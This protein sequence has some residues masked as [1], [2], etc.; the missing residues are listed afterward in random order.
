MGRY[1]VVD[2]SGNVTNVIV[3]DGEAQ[4]TPP[5]GTELIEVT[6]AAGPGWTYRDGEFIAPEEDQ[7]EEEDQTQEEE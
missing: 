2:K 5:E 4:Y 1:A 6:G 3:W 7:P